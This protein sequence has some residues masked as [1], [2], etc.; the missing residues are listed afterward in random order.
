MLNRLSSPTCHIH[1]IHTIRSFR[2]HIFTHGTIIVLTLDHKVCVGHSSA[3]ASHR[4]LTY[5]DQ[6][7]LCAKIKVVVD[8]QM[9]ILSTIQHKCMP[10][11]YFQSKLFDLNH[12]FN[13]YT[14]DF[15]LKFLLL[16]SCL[17]LSS[18]LQ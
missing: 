8:E 7:S 12:S 9:G 13:S 6:L 18:I 14:E 16:F 1:T 5:K 2:C 11:K 4:T 15:C 10:I 17:V 3:A